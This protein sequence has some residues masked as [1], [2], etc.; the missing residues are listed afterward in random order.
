MLHNTCATNWSTC[1]THSRGKRLCTSPN[2]RP[3]TLARACHSSCKL[4]EDA[5]ARS[6][7]VDRERERETNMLETM[8][9]VWTIVCLYERV[10]S[11][12]TKRRM[13][14]FLIISFEHSSHLLPSVN[15]DAHRFRNIPLTLLVLT[16]SKL[17]PWELTLRPLDLETNRLTQL[18]DP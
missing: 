14:K 12:A 18:I 1:V 6:K 10:V 17:R 3:L 7:K 16:S 2:T 5:S 15:I 8:Q 11:R 4:E 13:A 9:S